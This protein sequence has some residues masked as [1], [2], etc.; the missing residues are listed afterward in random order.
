MPEVSVQRQ[1]GDKEFILRT[2]KLALLADGAVVAKLGGTE[3]LVTATAN[4]TIREGIDFFPLTIDFEE[5][6][7]SV[8]RIPGSFFRREGRPSEQAILTNRLIDRP[9]RPSFADDFRN[10]THIV[11]TSLSVDHEN[12]FDVIALNGAS[13]ALTVSPIPFQGP[14]GGVRVALKKGEWVPFPT[15]QDLE[16]SVFELVVA[17]RRNDEGEIDIVMVEAG[18]TEDGLRLV[19]EGDAPSDEETVARGLE[20]SKQYISQLIDLQLELVSSVDIPEVEWPKAV[21]YTEEMRAR[22]TEVAASTV[23]EVIRL[24][25]K[26]ERNDAEDAALEETIVA[27]GIAEDD[28]ET[29]TQAKRAFKSLFKEMARRRVVEEGIRLDGRS[30]DEIRPLSVEVGVVDRTHGSGLFQRGETQ[31]LNITTLGMMKMEQMLDTLAL[32]ESKR[33]MHHYNFPPFSTGEAGFMRG[34]KRR[35]IGHGALAEKAVLPVVPTSEDFPYALRLVS[36]VLTSN[37]STSMA[38]VCAS[39]LSLMDAGVPI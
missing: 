22:V 20:E 2:G 12:P 8:G 32:A 6:M 29:R 1:I 26:K 9:L 7:Y 33:Y 23:A 30:A 27:L 13:A 18:A 39:S 35:E 11:V 14:I 24:P 19:A 28:L 36:E 15:E 34:P 10:E 17:G 3:M 21:D 31:V 5:R 25:G 16:E 38:S 4:K 37:G